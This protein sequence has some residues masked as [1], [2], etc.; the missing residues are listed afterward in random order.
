[1]KKAYLKTKLII[2]FIIAALGA[3]VFYV[4]KTIGIS[5]SPKTE[6]KE[7]A[8]QETREALKTEK[9]SN[10]LGQENNLP[11]T[12]EIKAVS[13]VQNEDISQAVRETVA[14][15][16][17]ID[18]PA[19]TSTVLIKPNI[20]SNGYY[21][22]TTNPEVVKTL[23]TMAFEAGAKKVIV[24]DSSGVGWPD[25]LKNMARTGLK[26][27]AE[28]AGAEVVDLEKKGWFKI[29][30]E[31]SKHWPD[32]FRFSE[33]INE[34]D[35]IISVPIIKT[36]ATTGI[37]LSLKNTVGLL[38]REDRL[39]MHRSKNIQEMIAEANL[40]Y[41]PDMIVFDGSK[42]FITRGPAVG[43]EVTGNYVIAGRERITSDIAAFKILKKL[44]ANLSGDGLDHPMIA[45][46]ND[47]G[48]PFTEVDID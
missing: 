25:T 33:I 19:P 29:K 42:S 32:G 26:Q 44:G 21:P 47:L 35:Y 24:A 27:A 39:K 14:Q 9:E 28:E 43:K 41:K 4:L 40:A 45:R 34:V 37:T 3:G 31:E 12:K 23:V 18:L 36:H 2:V 7:K 13:I 1:M 46:A 38:H 22:A 11:K 8:Y 6:Q 17:G 48:L 15:I 20:N 5:F 16:G 30:L 10:F